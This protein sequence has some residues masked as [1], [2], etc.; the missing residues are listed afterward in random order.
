MSTPN[1]KSWRKWDSEVGEEEVVVVEDDLEVAVE[2]GEG[3]VEEAAVEEVEV[4]EEVDGG[5]S[6]TF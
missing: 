4:A 6:S 2:D 1:C 3:V 5:D